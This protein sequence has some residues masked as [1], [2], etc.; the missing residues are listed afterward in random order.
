[1]GSNK[2]RVCALA[3]MSRK[4]VHVVHGALASWQLPG[5]QD[6]SFKMKEYALP[7]VF[8]VKGESNTHVEVVD[9]SC[10]VQQ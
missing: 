10:N 3:K 5:V 1:M 6:E 9:H 8:H 4:P 2:S 7:L